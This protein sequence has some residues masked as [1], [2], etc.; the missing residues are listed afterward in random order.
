MENESISDELVVKTNKLLDNIS[1]FGKDCLYDSEPQPVK[2][3]YGG[4]PCIS[5]TGE[6]SL[7]SDKRN[8]ASVILPKAMKARIDEEKGGDLPMFKFLARKLGYPEFS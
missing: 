2:K 4:R 8:V 1:Q 3:H 6:K 7:L 5:P